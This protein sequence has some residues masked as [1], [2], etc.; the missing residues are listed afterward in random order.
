MSSTYINFDLGLDYNLTRND[1]LC[2]LSSPSSATYS[3][4][5]WRVSRKHHKT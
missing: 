5:E 4:N 3:L 1:T 2:N